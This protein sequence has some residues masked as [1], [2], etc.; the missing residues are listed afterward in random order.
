MFQELKTH[1]RDQNGDK[2]GNRKISERKINETKSQFLEKTKQ[3]DKSLDR[4]PK[5]KREKTQLL[6]QQGDTAVN[7]T[8]RG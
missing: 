2:I 6:K 4:L 8:S 5:E 7:F 3:M 1:G